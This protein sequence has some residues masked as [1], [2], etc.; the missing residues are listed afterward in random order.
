MLESPSCI[1]DGSHVE[2]EHDRTG[3]F[4][5]AQEEG[6]LHTRQVR[7]RFE[8]NSGVFHSKLMVL[9]MVMS[10]KSRMPQENLGIKSTS[11][12]WI[13]YTLHGYML[14]TTHATSDPEK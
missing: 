14:G 9:M 8:F 2:E 10:G 12:C 6:R 3:V 4:F 7:L 1:E 11:L 5:S 13:F